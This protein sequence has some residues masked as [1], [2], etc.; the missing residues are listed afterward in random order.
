MID[1]EIK[2][3]RTDE[4]NG[5]GERPGNEREELEMTFDINVLEHLGLKMYSSLPAVVA[6]YVANSWDTGTKKVYIYAHNSETGE[7]INV[8]ISNNG[9]GMTFERGG[10]IGE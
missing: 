9:C 1:D 7:P 5:E 8:T 6:E 3:R 2:N 4:K 10:C